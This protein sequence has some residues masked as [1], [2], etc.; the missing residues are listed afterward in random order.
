MMSLSKPYARGFTLIEL[1]VVIAIIA[2]L[3][4]LLLP[5]VQQA[6]EAARR[7]QCKNNLKQIGLAMHNYHETFG[8]LPP[9]YTYGPGPV[10]ASIFG[11][12]PKTAVDDY[13]IHLYTEFLLPYLD[14]GP[15][16]NL[17]NFSQT[18]GSPVDMAPIGGPVHTAPNQTATKTVIPAYLCPSTPRSANSFSFTLAGMTSVTGA[19][20]YSPFGGIYST[21]YDTYVQP[22]RP[23]S[24]RSGVLSDNNNGMRFEHFM[25]GTSNTL[26][27]M[28][29][30]GR[31]DEYRRGKLFASNTLTGGGW[32]DVTNA[33][34][35]VKGSSVDG[36]T[37][38]GP[39]A[40]NCTSRGGDG[41]YSFHVGGIHALMGDGAVRFLGENMAVRTFADIGTPNGGTVTG[42]F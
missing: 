42:E 5:A 15:V 21:L 25:D 13:N 34:N 38:G 2:V 37:S 17:I 31:N 6:R 33:E 30:S 4:A 28:E 12:T 9:A 39:C 32:A 26:I 3:I 36:S 35:W 23:Q 20:D 8:R 29:L 11:A 40:I 24:D 19:M 18:Y 10:L 7:S 14:Q 27:L 16:Y 1:L 22:T 41:A